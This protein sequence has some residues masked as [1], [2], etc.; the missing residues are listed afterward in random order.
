MTC[1]ACHVGV[2]A[3]LEKPPPETMSAP[4]AVDATISVPP[5]AQLLKPAGGALQKGDLGA[6]SGVDVP[7]LTAVA[8]TARMYLLV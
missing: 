4:V 5:P 2:G 3:T 8:P 7:F 1:A 6:A